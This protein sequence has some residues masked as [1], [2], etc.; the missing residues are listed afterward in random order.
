MMRCIIMLSEIVTHIGVTRCPTYIELLLFN[1]F[2]DP[3]EYHVHGFASGFGALLLD[4][5]IDDVICGGV[6]SF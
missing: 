6:V 2:F 3:A 5:V 1:P 4:C